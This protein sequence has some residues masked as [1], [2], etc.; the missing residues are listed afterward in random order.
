MDLFAIPGD[1]G[2]PFRRKVVQT[3]LRSGDYIDGAT[4]YCMLVPYANKADLSTE[5]RVWL[6]YL[7]GLSYSCTTAIRM[8]E[9]LSEPQHLRGSQVKKFWVAEKPTLYFNPDRKYIKNND[10]V[11]LA[12]K[13]V[14]TDLGDSSLLS[15]VLEVSQE[16]QSFDGLYRY[17]QKTWKFFGPH[18]SYLFFDA[19]YGLCPEVYVD[20]THLDWKHCGK[21]VPEGMAHMLYQ[22][23]LI[24]THT[25]PFVVY[26]RM[27]DKLQQTTGQPKVLIESVLCAFRK[28][29]KGTRYV[30]YYADRMLE[31]CLF[32][33]S[34]RG[35]HSKPDVWGLRKA[36]VPKELRGEDQGWDGIRKDQTKRWLERGE[37]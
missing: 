15:R 1:A 28:F 20:P 36:S 6:A 26:D 11:A 13:S 14:K 10:Q 18:G 22:D 3:L 29:F 12:L 5:E 25:F 16:G 9:A 31:E 21:T 32:V 17:I 33:D 2:K 8:F 27:V 23:E 30:G 19:L 24:Q 37:P 4:D 34:L 7:Y 35:V